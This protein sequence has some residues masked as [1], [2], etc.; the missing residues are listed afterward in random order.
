MFKSKKLCLDC[1]KPYI[2]SKVLCKYCWN[3]KFGK[4]IKKVS[5]KQKEKNDEY[6]IIRDLFIKD[7]PICK[8]QINNRYSKCSN[9]STDIHHKRGRIGIYLTAVAYFLPVCR[10]CH[11]YIETHPDE[12]KELGFSENRL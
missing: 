11:S 4:P 9:E 6:K 2:F 3:I 10:S 5:D 1:N 8:A 7:N 12:S